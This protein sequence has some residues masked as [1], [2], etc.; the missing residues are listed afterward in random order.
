[1]E[2]AARVKNKIRSPASLILGVNLVLFA[3]EGVK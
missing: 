3:Y 2:L 1:M